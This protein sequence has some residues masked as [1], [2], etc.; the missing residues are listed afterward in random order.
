MKI[1]FYLI[2]NIC[3]LIKIVPRLAVATRCATYCLQRQPMA[4]W[5]CS[6]K[7]EGCDWLTAGILTRGVE[8]VSFQYPTRMHSSLTVVE[9][10]I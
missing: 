1:E 3:Q 8:L 6:K 2:F 10:P 9:T 7:Y 5:R 4:I